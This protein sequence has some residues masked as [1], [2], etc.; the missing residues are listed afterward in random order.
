M[1][2]QIVQQFVS[3]FFSSLSENVFETSSSLPTFSHIEQNISCMYLVRNTLIAE[4]QILKR[5]LARWIV[6]ERVGSHDFAS[7]VVPT[8]AFNFLKRIIWIS[9]ANFVCVETNWGLRTECVFFSSPERAVNFDSLILLALEPSFLSF[10]DVRAILKI[11]RRGF[12]L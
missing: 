4:L 7:L 9:L 2:P 6:E 3:R 12:R 11:Q 5:V 1:F 8:L 10:A